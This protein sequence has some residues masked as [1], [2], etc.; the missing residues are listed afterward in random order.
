MI[1]YVK[2]IAMERDSRRLITLEN[3]EISRTEKIDTE[4][5]NLFRDCQSALDVEKRYEEF[6]NELNPYS[7]EIVKV[8]DVSTEAGE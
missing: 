2:G 8:I 6:W 7:A 4:T 1:Y 3:G 5:N